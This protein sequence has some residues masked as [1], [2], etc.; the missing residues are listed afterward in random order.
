MFDGLVRPR[1]LLRRKPFGDLEPL[2]PGLK[3]PVYGEGGFDHCASRS[4]VADDDVTLVG[5]S[6]AARPSRA[7]ARHIT[8]GLIHRRPRPGRPSLRRR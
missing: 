8:T 6:V 3:R 7:A 2:L 1:D 4:V 5:V